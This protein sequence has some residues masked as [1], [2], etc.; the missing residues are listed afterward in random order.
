MSKTMLTLSQEPKAS[1]TT[2]S[3][4][5]IFSSKIE[6]IQTAES[7]LS[8]GHGGAESI[9]SCRHSVSARLPSVAPRP[10][11]R[12][13]YGSTMFDTEH[14]L[15]ACS[16]PRRAVRLSSGSRSK[17]TSV[18]RGDSN[19][20]TSER[21]ES[22]ALV[23]PGAGVG[24]DGEGNP[25]GVEGDSAPASVSPGDTRGAD[26]SSLAVS[27][28]TGLL[29]RDP[30]PRDMII[31]RSL[32]SLSAELTFRRISAVRLKP[33]NLISTGCSQTPVESSTEWDRSDRHAES[34]ASSVDTKREAGRERSAGAG[35]REGGRGR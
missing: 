27:D 14:E 11:S 17:S 23:G 18:L 13:L 32:V 35:S 20:V 25:V 6:S 8:Q 24:V 7:G 29:S 19:S 30:L 16:A 33:R 9:A 15:S 4:W 5:N 31:S 22:S 10:S 3:R 21:G 2:N 1:T 34:G 28:R 12:M 26:S